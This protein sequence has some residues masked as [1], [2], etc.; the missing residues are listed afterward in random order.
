MKKIALLLIGCVCLFSCEKKQGDY[1]YIDAQHILHTSNKCECI[2]E[3][4][5]A[6]PISI[7]S[8]KDLYH[9]AWEE[10]CSECVSDADYSKIEEQVYKNIVA[11]ERSKS[12]MRKLYDRLCDIGESQWYN[13]DNFYSYVQHKDNYR[14]LVI[15]LKQKGYD[16]TE[17][18]DED[19]KE[20]Y[21]IVDL[22]SIMQNLD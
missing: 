22:D 20:E 11:A 18:I 7:I 21:G 13:F 6:K 12:Y 10:F 17:W 9:G 3:I 1:V 14:R 5:K 16:I 15:Q 19:L 2:T 4:H 8:M